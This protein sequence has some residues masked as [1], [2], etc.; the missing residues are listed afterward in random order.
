MREN[1]SDSLKNNRNYSDQFMQI[2]SEH[3]KMNAIKRTLYKFI[4]GG[5]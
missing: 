2:Y 1:T 4:Y 5:Y 3:I